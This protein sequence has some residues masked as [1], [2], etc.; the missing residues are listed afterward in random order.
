MQNS[1]PHNG[2]GKRRSAAAPN[3]EAA[4][5]SL[6]SSAG[7][8]ACLSPRRASCASQCSGAWGK[9]KD[10]LW[11]LGYQLGDPPPTG[12]GVCV[13]SNTA[14]PLSTSVFEDGSSPGD[15]RSFEP[16]ACRDALSTPLAPRR[17]AVNQR[18]S[19]CNVASKE[20]THTCSASVLRRPW[21]PRLLR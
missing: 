1:R 3:S 19:R 5:S 6:P 20:L 2:V 8:G 16:R 13:L 10:Q 7:E 17:D 18:D 15:L 4:G 12:L 21:A 11:L 14:S 9:P